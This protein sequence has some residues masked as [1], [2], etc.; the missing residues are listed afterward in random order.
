MA[1]DE[2]GQR[3][4]SGRQSQ[5]L[6]GETVAAQEQLV[7][8]REQLR[9]EREQ[10]AADRKR[11]DD[12]KSSASTLATHSAS[13]TLDKFTIEIACPKSGNLK[14]DPTQEVLRGRWLWSDVRGMQFHEQ[15]TALPDMGDVPGLH[16]EIDPPNHRARIY[17][18]YNLSENKEL[19][20]NAKRV[21]ESTPLA[22]GC[23]VMPWPDKVYNFE[24]ATQLKTW[25]Y[26]AARAVD[27][28]HAVTVSG[29]VPKPRYIL[30]LLDG[31]TEVGLADSGRA[32]KRRYVEDRIKEEGELV[33]V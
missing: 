10:L 29:R 16:I 12:M 13:G 7:A 3:N 14:W 2:Q 18:P 4:Q 19:W 26:H 8:E 20:A 1:K 21:F 24:T 15:C 33:G 30:D 23:E 11:F 28:G 17:D 27:Q 6:D 31:K 22:D 32:K 25:C 5:K 9:I